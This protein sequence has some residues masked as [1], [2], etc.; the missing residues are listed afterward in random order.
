VGYHHPAGILFLHRLRFGSQPSGLETPNLL[1]LK[2]KEIQQRWSPQ[3]PELTSTSYNL[4]YK[5]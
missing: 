1:K 4:K 5:N 3:A 2:L